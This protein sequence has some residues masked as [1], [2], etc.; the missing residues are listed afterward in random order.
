M[1]AVAT[2][3]A[4]P[5]V[6][7]IGRARFGS[8]LTGTG[9]MIR[10]ILRRDRVR[11]FWWTFSIV[12]FYLYFMAA[13]GTFDAEAM[14]GRAALME[15]PS[16]IAMGGPGY[17]VE[18]YTPERAVANEGITWWVIA[19]GVMSILHMVRH[20]RTEEESSRSELVRANVVGRHAPAVAAIA[21]LTL[22]NALIAVFSAGIIVAIGGEYVTVAD[23]FGL[24]VGVALASMVFGV[25]AF[26]FAQLT[27]HGRGAIGLSMAVLGAAF[28]ARAAG[29][30]METHGSPLSW[31]SPFAWAQQMRPFV[32]LI[33]WPA[34]LSVAVIVLLLLLG[35]FLASRRDFGGGMLAERAGRAEAG[36][37]LAGPVALAW[38]QQR[39]A[40]FWCS[41]GLGLM[42]FATGTMLP[43]IADLMRDMVESN[44]L[45]GAVFGN[46]PDGFVT[47]F[48]GIM[49]LYGILCVAAYAIVMG[50]RAKAEESAGR[51]EI[52]LARPLAR[53]TW[54]G[55]QLLVAGI[56]TVVMTAVTVYAM[57]AGG[58]AVGDETFSFGDY[59]EVLWPYLPAAL[60]YLGFTAVLYAWFPKATG[61]GWLLL[62]YGFVIGMF[63]SLIEDLPE[64][65]NYANP[66]YWVPEAF[67]ESPEPS[68]MIGLGVAVVVLFGLAFLGF[69]RRDIPAV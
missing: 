23:S 5:A 16:G 15:T 42:W 61:L 49:L 19:L 53:S 11:I 27:V 45:V 3:P 63:G 29:D 52:V 9:R 35:S 62:V 28:F 10:F 69:R 40:L 50:G 51:A 48:L 26:V 1:S 17:G 14:A 21:T 4:G 37:S 47:A 33:W 46:D 7:T 67:V 38:R 65:A 8:T 60:C 31:S 30:M 68:H 13:L 25:V 56:G 20:T 43:D 12:A 18:D 54:Y 55:A 22:V 41:L 39:W 6:P 32:D 2:A 57:W 34:L 64:A 66:L 24:T 36:G 44:P 58:V 59:T